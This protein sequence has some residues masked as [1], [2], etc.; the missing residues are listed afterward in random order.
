MAKTRTQAPS[1]P[2]HGGDCQQRL[3]VENY[4]GAGMACRGNMV[5]E[6]RN[7][8]EEEDS[9]EKAKKFA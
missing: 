9:D 8:L 6:G 1:P 2:G 3:L 7:L 4:S 5:Q